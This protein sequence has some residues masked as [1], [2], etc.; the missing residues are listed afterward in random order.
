[1]NIRTL[2]LPP[3]ALTGLWAAAIWWPSQSSVAEEHDRLAAIQSDQLALIT[4]FN[5]LSSGAEQVDA[6]NAELESLDVAIPPSP[7]IAAFVRQLDAEAD[8]SQFE[9]D[10]LAPTLV[11]GGA[12]TDP[13]RVVPP[14]MSSV[15]FSITGQGSF[16][17]AMAFVDRVMTLPRL[18][19]VDALGLTSVEGDTGQVILDLD[20]R[21]FTTDQMTGS[22]LGQVVAFDEPAEPNELDDLDDSVDLTP[23]QDQLIERGRE[24]EEP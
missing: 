15:S 21:I 23:Q 20:L 4:E 24:V 2:V 7:D 18:I 6:L 11:L 14:G 5:D 9:I 13:D 8:A 1:M 3:M 16:E 19:V 17:A 12:A 22:D 10:L